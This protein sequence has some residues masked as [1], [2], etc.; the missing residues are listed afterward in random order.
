[1]T[2]LVLLLFFVLFVCLLGWLVGFFAVA[3]H[4]PPPSPAPPPPPSPTIPDFILARFVGGNVL[5]SKV[6]SVV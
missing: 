2:H 4:S 1:M 3:S 5:N 6:D